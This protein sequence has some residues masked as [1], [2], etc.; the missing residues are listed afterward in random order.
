MLVKMAL[1]HAC[2]QMPFVT[3]SFE[4][5]HPPVLPS[6]ESIVR[7][8][9]LGGMMLV[10]QSAAPQMMPYLRWAFDL[11]PAPTTAMNI[12]RKELYEAT[13]RMTSN[14]LGWSRDVIA[15]TAIGVVCLGI[16]YSFYHW[17]ENHLIS[18]RASMQMAS[19]VY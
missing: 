3:I 15:I 14:A 4:S 17:V 16:T 7:N 2:I 19:R 10:G 11:P 5:K 8:N 9:L 6:C 12:P 1:V 13:S 18:E